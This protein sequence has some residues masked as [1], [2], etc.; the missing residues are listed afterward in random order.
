VREAFIRLEQEGL[1][2]NLPN[3][4]GFVK[5]FTPEDVREIF[6]LRAA[7]EGVAWQ[8]AAERM[9]EK[10]LQFLEDLLDEQRKATTKG[11]HTGLIKLDSQFHQYILKVAGEPPRLL[12]MWFELEAQRQAV[13]NRLYRVSPDIAPAVVEWDHSRIL[14]AFRAEDIGRLMELN[15]ETNAVVEERCVEAFRVNGSRPH[16]AE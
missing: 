10:H 3:R 14:Q 8:M 2:E 13:L 6:R 7:L 4:G 15:Q 16:A 5:D 1:I 12:K 11:D 9:T